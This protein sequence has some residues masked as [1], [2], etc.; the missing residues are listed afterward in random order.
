MIKS[1]LSNAYI[2]LGLRLL[3]G[4]TFL[5]AGVDKISDPA[6][7]ARAI[8]NYRLITGTPAV[9]LATVLPWIELLCGLTVLSGL[10]LRGS[11]LLLLVM[12]SAFTLAV[13]TGLIRGLDISC[14]CFTLDPNVNRIGWQK[15]LENLGLIA[16]SVILLYFGNS[17]F[18]LRT[19]H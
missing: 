10:Y 5:F 7:F 6:A 11:S 8:E 15:V 19:D 1:V 13:M 4:L 2:S 14:G 12:L 3:L 18:S 17:R 9:V 16:T